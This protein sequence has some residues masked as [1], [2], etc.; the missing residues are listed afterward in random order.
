MADAGDARMRSPS[1]LE[2]YGLKQPNIHLAADKLYVACLPLAPVVALGLIML[3]LM[4]SS[5]A[6]CEQITALLFSAPERGLT[7]TNLMPFVI[8][9]VCLGIVGITYA[10]L[11]VVAGFFYGFWPAC[12]A[13]AIVEIV[14][15][16][17]CFVIARYALKER[18]RAWYAASTVPGFIQVAVAKFD[19]RELCSVVL[20]RA[21]PIPGVF[22][23]YLPS[24]LNVSFGA[25]VS[26][27]LLEVFIYV[28]WYSY[29]GTQSQ[30][31]AQSYA[32]DTAIDATG[33]GVYITLL[34]SAITFFVCVHFA[35]K[36]LF[37]KSDDDQ[38]V[39][40]GPEMGL[41]MPIAD[42]SNLTTSL[43]DRSNSARL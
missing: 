30:K 24:L 36:D 31:L 35:V 6:A 2:Q 26:A 18:C 28:P 14:T 8:L 15:P 7:F 37:S 21:F 34:L 29:L 5:N 4:K 12:L 20:F 10:P 22:K 9:N 40:D 16:C 38:L 19:Q 32:K 42:K 1:L 27:V 43:L 25:Y 3:I 11:L 41:L 23:N 39:I 17:V 33:N 13:N